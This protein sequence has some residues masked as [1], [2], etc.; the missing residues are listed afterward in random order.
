[1]RNIDDGDSST[2]PSTM[3]AM[4]D[5]EKKSSFATGEW[6]AQR[7]AA[8]KADILPSTDNEVSSSSQLSAAANNSS[9]TVSGRTERHQTSAAPRHQHQ[10]TRSRSPRDNT[11]PRVRTAASKMSLSRS[12]SSQMEHLRQLEVE[13]E[14]QLRQRS[15]SKLPSTSAKQMA[16]YYSEQRPSAYGSESRERELLMSRSA[17]IYHQPAQRRPAT[18]SFPIESYLAQTTG[19]DIHASSR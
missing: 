8:K 11:P 1:M 15:T 5:T 2:V 17:N 12:Q 18:S 7:E 16:T 6:L 4:T 14:H 9:S 19:R 3:L 10:Q 13:L